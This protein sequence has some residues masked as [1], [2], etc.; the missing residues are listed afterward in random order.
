LCVVG[1]FDSTGDSTVPFLLVVLVGSLVFSSSI[2]FSSSSHTLFFSLSESDA[3]VKEVSNLL[4]GFDDW[5]AVNKD[6]LNN[7]RAAKKLL[8]KVPVFGSNKKQKL[9]KQHQD[10]FTTSSDK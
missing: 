9:S 7:D 6:I 4:Q 8:G 5:K 1:L 3:D 10:L 2:F